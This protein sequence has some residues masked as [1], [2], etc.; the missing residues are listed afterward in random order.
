[1]L[2]AQETHLP[3]LP[4]TGHVLTVGLSSFFMCLALGKLDPGPIHFWVCGPVRGKLPATHPLLFPSS[5]FLG[6]YS[7]VL[8]I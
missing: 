8:P 4:R 3:L 2:K 5:P 6:V 7:H 1:M